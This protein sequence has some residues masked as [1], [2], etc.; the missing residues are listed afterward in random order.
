MRTQWPVRECASYRNDIPTSA[1][2]ATVARAALP[3]FAE[4]ATDPRN[5]DAIAPNQHH[6]SGEWSKG[7]GE[8]LGGTP[9]ARSRA[10]GANREVGHKAPLV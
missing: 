4:C 8:R 3:R 2:F 7:I 5:E 10:R 1:D 9:L 6:V